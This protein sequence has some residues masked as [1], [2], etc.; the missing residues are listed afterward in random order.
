[1]P[2]L[3]II[4]DDLWRAVADRL[5]KRK[6]TKASTAH[7]NI[8]YPFAGIIK[9]ADCGAT[10]MAIKTSRKGHTY[11]NYACSYN[12]RRG[13]SICA[14]ST[15]VD[16][17]T[18]MD[19]VMKAIEENILNEESVAIITEAIEKLITE[20]RGSHAADRK[21][22]EKEQKKLDKEIEK[23]SRAMT[24]AT[25]VPEL[26]KQ[27]QEKAKRR[28]TVADA[29][30]GINSLVKKDLLVGLEDR[31]R[32]EMEDIRGLLASQDVHQFRHELMHHVSAILVDAQ[33]QMRIEGS[34]TGALDSVLKLVAGAGLEPATSRL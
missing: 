27:L 14:N 12:R 29:L 17:A 28:T 22:L 18:L 23:L 6:S 1:M 21:R 3:R 15:K 10:Y 31:V 32:A 8:R 9:C 13:S 2:D 20:H 24:I 4:T 7:R 33:G 26:A 16:Q 25:D 5:G 11:V 34:L 19:S 30:D